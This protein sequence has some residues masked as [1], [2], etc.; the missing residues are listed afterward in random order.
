MS[1]RREFTINGK[2]YYFGPK[3]GPA[4]FGMVPTLPP[5]LAHE[6]SSRPTPEWEMT[7]GE[8]TP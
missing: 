1:D 5:E 2:T 8:S 6:W 3:V 7:I 4:D